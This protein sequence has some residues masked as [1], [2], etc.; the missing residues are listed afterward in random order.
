MSDIA[1]MED[2]PYMTNDQIASAATALKLTIANQRAQ[3]QT[4]NTVLAKRK[5]AA[6]KMKAAL[7]AYRRNDPALKAK[8]LE[9]V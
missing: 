5:Y 1:N 8:H 2:L 7:D 4:L 9:N 6:R 3:L